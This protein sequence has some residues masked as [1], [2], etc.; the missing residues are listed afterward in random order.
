MSLAI[1]Y[2]NNTL[3]LQDRRSIKKN[4]YDWGFFGGALEQNETF[5]Q[6]LRREVREELD[7][8]LKDY[9]FFEKISFYSEKYS[10]EFVGHYYVSELPPDYKNQFTVLKGDGMKLV[11]MDDTK[12]YFL[13]N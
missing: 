12:I 2:K 7:Y 3:L 5:D 9:A 4:S 11:T 13:I 1:F 10:K 6:A 8:D